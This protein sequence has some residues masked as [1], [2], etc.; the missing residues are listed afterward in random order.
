M[1]GIT[2]TAARGTPAAGGLASESRARARVSRTAWVGV[3]ALVLLAPF[4]SLTPL[5]ALPGQSL[6]TVE[7]ALVCVFATW[8][9][10]LA[11]RRVMPVW[12]TPFT[13]P[14]V[15]L[16]AVMLVAAV[17]APANRA[18]ALHMAGRFGVGFAVFLLTVNGAT[19]STRVRGVLVAAAAAGA[20][21]SG[22]VVVDYVG[23][24][25]V[26]EWL[27]IFRERVSVIGPQVRAAG[28]FQYPTIASMY[29]E[30]VFALVLALLLTTFDASRRSLSLLV[31]LL[32][33]SIAVA[34]TLTFTRAGLVTMASSVG[35]VGLLRYRRHGVDGAV[36]AIV[37]LAAL[38]VIQFLASRP[39]EAVLLR[40]TTE[41]QQSWYS[42]VVEAPA[43][44]AMPAGAVVSIP[45]KLTNSGRSTWD[46]A[47][48]TPFLLSY[49]WLEADGERVVEF[50]GLRT[51]FPTVVAPGARV[52]VDA[53][54]KAPG[55]PG[56]YRLLWDVVLER[57][58]W[59]STNPNAERFFS[60]AVV[61][62]SPVGPPP[63]SRITRMPRATPTPDRLTLWRAGARMVR[64][65]PLLG[66]GPDN[67]RLTYGEYAGLPQFDTRVHSN[68]MYLEMFVGGGI[69]GGVAFVWLCA[70]AVTALVR[71]VRGAP[72]QIAAAAAGVAAGGAAIAL[73]GIVDSFLS[74][75]GTYVLISIT[76]GLAATVA[77]SPE[78]NRGCGDG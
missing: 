34:I 22:L 44:V 71:T 18:N 63:V 55:V 78:T 16:V 33:V 49:H 75:T 7:T 24:G 54:V 26:A 48:A 23:A 59:F 20:I 37:A 66:V 65:H 50:E 62:G 45:V 40:M 64:A 52:A 76:L 17:A 27:T 31:F 10:A 68:N 12:R 9:A 3:C 35:I 32:L 57:R 1:N 74:F 67:F 15:L 21:V 73:H 30:I 77:I 61:T 13:L 51:A 72:P 53:R 14:W 19:T 36:R 47:A 4:E 5:V 38:I 46:P 70:S 42:A 29:L 39:V 43:D 11:W 2:A 28:P 60:S 6:T 56:R 69:I 58:L 25:A 8:L 41:G